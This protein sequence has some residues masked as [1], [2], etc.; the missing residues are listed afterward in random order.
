M[1]TASRLSALP[2]VETLLRHPALTR[3]LQSIPRVLVVE[4]VRAELAA[5]RTRLRAGGPPPAADHLAERA[6]ARAETDWKP[7][8]RR[9]L[10]ATGIVLH[11]N[12]GRAPLSGEARAALDQVAAGYSNLE[13]DLAT[14]RRGER[15]PGVERWLKR[16]T[17]AEAALVV[18]NGAA[19]VL[20]TL[21]ALAAGRPV[22]VSR[23]E[24]VEIGGSFRIPEILEKSG[25]TLVEVGTTN[26]THL[27][28]YERAFE[29]RGGPAAP[30]AIL[31]VHPSNFRIA[32]FTARP[33]LA[34]L[35]AL[36]HARR[37][38]LIEDLGSGALVDLAAFGLEHE[39]TV[40]ESLTAGC[41]IVTFSGDKLAGASQAGLVLGRR[42]LVERIRRDPLA[43][44]VRV[45]KLQLAALEATL[46]SWSDPERAAREIPAL[47]MLA[48]P[49]P[50]LERRAR[51]LAAG[52]A[53]RLPAGQFSV[54]RGRGEVG[55]G[56]L[57]LARLEGWVVAA[58]VPGR[59]ADE[60]DRRARAAEPPVIG[61]IRE[62]KFRLD[63][64]TLTDDEV[65]VAAET[66]G[67]AW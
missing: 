39:P 8:L 10:N 55:G 2:A 45:D 40:R 28:D 16:L 33:E 23:G 46:P 58:G 27:A 50:E 34:E 15:A 6:A 57:P 66:L 38:F 3:S 32:G 42:R 30:A 47:A 51:A 1:V 44:A 21:S 24:L 37:A 26:R 61:Y 7:S 5:E 17:G 14:G 4:A 18:N 56:S 13:F 53:Q 36:A 25:A 41:D 43:R 12:L 67:R 35:S 11:T 59:A 49:G 19:A 63:V 52:L 9:V 54:E 22:L 31:R 65:R 62:G 48:T 29:R 20:T 60:L 64:R